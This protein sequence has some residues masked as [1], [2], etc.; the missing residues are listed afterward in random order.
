MDDP[1]KPTQPAQSAPERPLTYSRIEKLSHGDTVLY[2]IGMLRFAASRLRD[3]K[4]ADSQDAWVYLEDFLLH[5]RNLI[6]FLGKEIADLRDGDL[7]VTNIWGMMQLPAPGEPDEIFSKGKQLRAKYEPVDKQGGGR[8]SQY[9]QHCTE[10]RTDPKDWAVSE[11]T[12]EIEPLLVE[13]EKHLEPKRNR[14]L[15]SVPPVQ[16]AVFHSASTAVYTPTVSI[17]MV[18]R[19]PESSA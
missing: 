4:W 3:G 6:D 5:F 17:Q 10:K 19:N 8:I 12:E 13:I 9:L 18:K 7:H 2:E 1:E 11:M 14:D 16:F 15:M